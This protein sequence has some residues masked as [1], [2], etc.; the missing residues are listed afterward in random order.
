MNRYIKRIAPILFA[1]I[2]GLASC[3]ESKTSSEEEAELTKMDSTSK[4]VKETTA[5]L[6]TETEKVEASLEKLDEEFE[7]AK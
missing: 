6:E 1:A 7:T 4:E 2:F 3:T 5:K